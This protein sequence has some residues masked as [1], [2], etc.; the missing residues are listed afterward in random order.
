MKFIPYA[1]KVAIK[2]DEFRTHEGLIIYQQKR[3]PKYTTGVVAAIGPPPI[4]SKGIEMPE[5]PFTVGD[6]VII[7]QAVWW[8]VEDYMIVDIEKIVAV[9]GKDVKF[10]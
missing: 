3:G 2:E 8:S 10:G 4:N 9:I 7:K 6:R 1:G 5:P